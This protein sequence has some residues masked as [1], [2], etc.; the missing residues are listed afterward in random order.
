MDLSTKEVVGYALSQTPNAQLIAEALN[1]VIK[2]KQPSTQDLL[3]HSD[4][5]VQYSA[6]LFRNR[7]SKLNITQSMSRRGNC[8]DNAVMKR[9]FRSLKTERLNHLLFINHQSLVST[10]EGY[11]RFY[12]YERR[13][14]GLD[15]MTPHQKYIEMKKA[16]QNISNFT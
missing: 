15:Y 14:S 1:N 8:W 10:V 6:S 5:G 13:H 12:N 2:C 7:L 16:A 3:L 9:F 11:I 4:R